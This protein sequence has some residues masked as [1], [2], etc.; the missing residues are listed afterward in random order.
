MVQRCPALTRAGNNVTTGTVLV[1][2][3]S[4]ARANPKPE[5][6][7]AA[8]GLTVVRAGPE[9]DPSELASILPRAVAWIAGTS[10][11]TRDL[12]NRAPNLRV[13]AR[14]GVG[15]DSVDLA[16]AT[17]NGIWVTNTPGANTD[18]VADLAVALMLDAVRHV[19]VSVA[20]VAAGEWSARPGRE[21]GAATVGLVGFGR[22]GQA[23]ARRVQSFG[24][25]V[26]ACDPWLDTTPVPGVDLVDVTVI[27]Q[28]CDIVSLHAPG[29][30]TVAD[31][32]WI[33]RMKPGATLVNTA[34]G[35]LVDEQALAA[36]IRQGRIAGY[37]CDTLAV[38][39]ASGQPSPLQAADLADR[40][41]I[42]P[43]LGAQTAEAVT[44]MGQMSARNVLAALRGVVP[45]H[46]V[47]RPE[48]NP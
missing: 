13:V 38:E 12:L 16:A 22:I 31:A 36:A 18:A 2:S 46:P 47:N 29:G 41:L 19:S 21:L 26:L 6:D 42:T 25:R 33:A 30:S 1:T 15:V 44:R 23:V 20:A 34:R 45:P 3:R 9:H 5:I 24:A 27:A 43:H 11:V 35:D 7:L 37:A 14:Y 17:L 28:E 39:H 4:F 40:V 8:A 48:L 10:P 32:S